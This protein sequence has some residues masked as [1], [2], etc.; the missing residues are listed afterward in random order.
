M[1]IDA[2]SLHYAVGPAIAV[3]MLVLIALFL[4]WA[5]AS[6]SSS[7]K[8]VR[9]EELLTPVATL[10][11]RES[12]LALRAVLSD[13]GIRSTIREP[14]AHR[15]DVLVFPED[16]DRARALALSFGGR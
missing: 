4:R 13:A 14:A 10:T 3:L 15:A 6:G 16:L 12:A 7:A 8:P 2:G 1:P 5:F 11:R 9:R